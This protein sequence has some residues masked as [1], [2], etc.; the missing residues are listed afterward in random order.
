[1]ATKAIPPLE[2]IMD[3]LRARLPEL[4]DC[5]GIKSL[6]VFGSYVRGHQRRGSDLDILIGFADDAHPNLLDFLRL[7]EELSCFLG[8]K[9][10]LVESVALKPY[11]GKRILQEVIYL[12]ENETVHS[13]PSPEGGKR[14]AR[15]A[16]EIRDYLQD[17]LESV[18]AVEE[19]TRGLSFDEFSSDRQRVYAAL[20]GLFIVGE[21]TRRIPPNLRRKHP[22][23]PWTSIIGL[24]N[25]VAHEYFAV[26]LPRIWEIVHEEIPNLRETVAAMLKDVEEHSPTN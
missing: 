16:R 1:M 11:I 4:R 10:D 9:V 8:V 26:Y 19:F 15:R 20:H 14:L 13:T 2:D 22:E 6:G 12:S 3:A 25:V 18:A 7:Q 23:I 21:A 24:R 5:Y 17:I